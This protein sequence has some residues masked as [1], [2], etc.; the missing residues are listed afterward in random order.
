MLRTTFTETRYTALT[1]VHQGKVRYH[2]GLT[3]PA[4]P[5]QNRNS[6]AEQAVLLSSVITP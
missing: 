5:C 6:V 1:A 3:R 4:V 2:N